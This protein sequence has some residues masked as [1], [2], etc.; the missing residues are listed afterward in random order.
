MRLLSVGRPGTNLEQ[1]KSQ[2]KGYSLGF[3]PDMQSFEKEFSQISFK[4]GKKPRKATTGI[5]SRNERLNSDKRKFY[6]GFDD[7]E[8]REKL[9]SKQNGPKPKQRQKFEGR[10]LIRARRNELEGTRISFRNSK[11][12]I[13][14]KEHIDNYKKEKNMDFSFLSNSELFKV[15]T[16]TK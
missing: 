5:A 3:H 10:K 14:A 7:V 15:K 13:G 11:G 9:L 1:E 8:L 2:S 6:R 4:F 16:L 12:L